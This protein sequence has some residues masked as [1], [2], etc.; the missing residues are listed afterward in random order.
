M[1]LLIKIDIFI[2]VLYQLTSFF[3]YSSLTANY[4]HLDYNAS[5]CTIMQI[6]EE[7]LFESQYRWSWNVKQE[8]KVSDTHQVPC[9]NSSEQTIEDWVQEPGKHILGQWMSASDRWNE[10]IPILKDDRVDSNEA[11]RAADIGEGK[12]RLE[13]GRSF[14]P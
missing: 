13:R 12:V 9:F 3:V 6:I 11:P 8:K 2:R 7:L 5:F 10:G 4:K 14:Y 1:L